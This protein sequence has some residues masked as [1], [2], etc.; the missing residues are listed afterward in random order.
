MQV[1]SVA[2]L[3][4]FGSRSISNWGL[5]FFV[6]VDG[7]LNYLLALGNLFVEVLG[8]VKG[9]IVLTFVRILTLLEMAG[10]F[11]LA[12]LCLFFESGRHIVFGVFWLDL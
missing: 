10:V 3:T 4:G 12:L 8:D 1:S 5:A 2:P 7:S 9:F 11:A 6:L